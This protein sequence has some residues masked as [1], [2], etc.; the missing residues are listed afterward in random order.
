M[1]E[2]I[3]A[4]FSWSDREDM[5][6]K[7]TISDDVITKNL[8]QHDIFSTIIHF[9]YCSSQTSASKNCTVE[10]KFRRNYETMRIEN[11]LNIIN[12]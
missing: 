5:I 10:F 2:K 12:Y 3:L 6:E 4:I 8:C 11:T 1:I 7:E 9:C